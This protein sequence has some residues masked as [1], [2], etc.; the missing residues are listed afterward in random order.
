MSEAK[1]SIPRVLESVNWKCGR[2]SAG[3]Q[4]TRTFPRRVKTRRVRP[5]CGS[6]GLIF[7]SEVLAS[8]LQPPA[9]AG[10]SDK[11]PTPTAATL[12]LRHP[13]YEWPDNHHTNQSREVEPTQTFKNISKTF[14]DNGAD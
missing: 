9:T 4:F 8:H 3:T 11:W 7:E 5:L 6:G 12:Y 14:L 13:H 2:G 1:T 10:G